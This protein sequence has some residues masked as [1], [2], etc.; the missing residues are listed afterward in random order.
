MCSKT[1]LRG[2]YAA[3]ALM[4]FQSTNVMAATDKGREF[5]KPQEAVVALQ[6]AAS[7]GNFAELRSLFG[8]TL[9]EIAN[10][11]QVQ[12]ANEVAT[13]AKALRETNRLVAV[14]AKRMAIEYGPNATLFPVPLVESTGR[15]HF[16]TPAGAQELI[17]RR[18]GRNEL[19]VLDVIR[20][21][22]QAQ[23]EYA[24]AD[25][26]GDEVLEY[27]QKIASSEGSKDGLFWDPDLDG[28]MSPL[29]PLVA[30]ARA[31][32][33]RKRAEDERQPFHGYYFK[34]LTSQGKHAP[35][36]KYDYIINKNMIGGFALVAWPAVYDETGVMTFI[37]N[38]QGRVY[39]RDLGAKT[40][41]LAESMK[42]Y[43]PDDSWCP[44]P[45]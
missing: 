23:R 12:A 35:G 38:Q 34:I 2:C 4:A 11:D 7:S 19:D 31:E 28:T 24:S 26:D 29:G 5:A 39:Q 14:A 17:N 45:D 8:P 16:D 30:D 9:D 20:T 41:K 3:A 44:S 32:G 25:R 21:Y 33:Y 18:I 22:V 15:W 40:G 13:F 36:G 10:P 1:V 37:V 27:A 43:D 42:T 6:S